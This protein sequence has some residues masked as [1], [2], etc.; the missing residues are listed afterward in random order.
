MTWFWWGGWGKKS[1]AIRQKGALYF[2]CETFCPCEYGLFVPA[3][4][5][6]RHK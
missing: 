4:M 6:E 2:E 5:N 1:D 3:N